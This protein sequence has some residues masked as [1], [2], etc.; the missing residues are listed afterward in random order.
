MPALLQYIVPI[1]FVRSTAL[2]V[3]PPATLVAVHAAATQAK[4]MLLEVSSDS[5][6]SAVIIR[7]PLEVPSPVMESR[8]SFRTRWA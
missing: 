6:P 1:P 5:R 3:R 7:R 8:L 4:R 2:I